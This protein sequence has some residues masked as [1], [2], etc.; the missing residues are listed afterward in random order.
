MPKRKS[1]FPE[2]LRIEIVRRAGNRCEYC[3]IR[4]DD[5]E[6]TF[7]L[8]HI[9]S[10]KHGGLTIESNLAFTCPDCNYNK[11]ANIG[12]FLHPPE[13]HFTPLFH[14]RVD[15]WEEHFE[16]IDG[17]ISPRTAIGEATARVLML[18]TP[19]RIILRRELANF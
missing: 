8:D 1:V 16:L 11:G 19:E 6:Y 12:T 15:K 14:P 4:Q 3:R 10:L 13:R 2:S 5:I 17:F 9:I 18:N 7:H